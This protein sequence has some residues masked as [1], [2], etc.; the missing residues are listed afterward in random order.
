MTKGYTCFERVDEKERMRVISAALIIGLFLFTLVSWIESR[1]K[2][3]EI[4]ETIAV[5]EDYTDVEV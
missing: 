5:A 2:A 3:N 4:K 1:E